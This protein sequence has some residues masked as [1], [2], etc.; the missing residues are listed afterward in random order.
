MMDPPAAVDFYTLLRGD[1]VYVSPFPLPRLFF[2][3]FHA[4]SL[5]YIFRVHPL[6]L[7]DIQC[8]LKVT[9]Q[10]D[11]EEMSAISAFTRVMD[12]G[13]AL[14]VC[15]QYVCIYICVYSSLCVFFLLP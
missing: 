11:A 3:S 2:F 15:M 8:F 13:R 6:M 4:L 14:N 5:P 1:S 9:A 7:I 10:R 12:L